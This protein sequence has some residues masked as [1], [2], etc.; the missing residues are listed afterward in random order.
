MEDLHHKYQREG[1]TKSLG[2]IFKVIMQNYRE[3]T[4]EMGQNYNIQQFE[5]HHQKVENLCQELGITTNYH[6]GLSSQ[7]ISHSGLKSVFKSKYSLIKN[8]LHRSKEVSNVK[9]KQIKRS[10]YIYFTNLLF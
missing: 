1:K 5:R 10:I 9:L 2:D 3:S 4:P 6:Q 7:K 8:L